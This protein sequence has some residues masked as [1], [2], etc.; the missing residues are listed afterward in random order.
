MSRLVHGSM[1][2]PTAHPTPRGY[3]VPPYASVYVSISVWGYMYGWY[4]YTSVYVSTSPGKWRLCVRLPNNNKSV[5]PMF[6]QGNVL[7]D[8]EK[9]ELAHM[10]VPWA[11]HDGQPK[12]SA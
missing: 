4:M 5:L 6:V 12:T 2:E 3:F 11:T 1:S 9:E 10:L 8:E 7:S